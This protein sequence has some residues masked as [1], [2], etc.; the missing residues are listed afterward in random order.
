MTG[1]VTRGVSDAEEANDE[2]NEERE[3]D[4]EPHGP[5]MGRR[6]NGE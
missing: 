3:P 5:E 4:G 2:D 1:R 6:D